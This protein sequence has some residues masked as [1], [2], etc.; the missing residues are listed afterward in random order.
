ML[1]TYEEYACG[2]AADTFIVNPVTALTAELTELNTG[3][4]NA[5]L[6][7]QA[8]EFLSGSSAFI[9]QCLVPCDLPPLPAEVAQSDSNVKESLAEVPPCRECDA[10]RTPL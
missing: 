8:A 5:P 3:C 9:W 10:C 2:K 6:G 7:L 1:N 4:I